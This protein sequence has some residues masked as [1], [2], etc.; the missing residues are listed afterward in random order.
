MKKA[1]ILFVALLVFVLLAA[2]A[3]LAQEQ[4]ELQKIT[5][6]NREVSN[7]VVI[8]AAQEG[9]NSF[10][11]RCNKDVPGCTMLQPG[12]YLM[13]R[14][15]KNRGIYDCENVHIYRTSTDSEIGDTIGEYCLVGGK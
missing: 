14:L 2:V 7:G 15:P 9:K 13:L 5:V 11:L 3:L 12:D 4:R 8:L 1:V 10:E 6:R